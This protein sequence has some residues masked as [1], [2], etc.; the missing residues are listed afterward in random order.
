M[1]LIMCALF[2][3]V[4]CAFTALNLLIIIVKGTWPVNIPQ[5]QSRNIILERSLRYLHIDINVI[6]TLWTLPLY[7]LCILYCIFGIL[8][9]KVLQ[10]STV[11]GAICKFSM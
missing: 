11:R 2:T 1:F 5:Q 7:L 3:V 10:S 9:C 4:S 6:V 8:A